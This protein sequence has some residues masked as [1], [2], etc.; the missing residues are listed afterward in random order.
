[1]QAYPS[2]EQT[3]P[4]RQLLL[5]EDNPLFAEQI[6][7]AMRGLPERWN[8]LEFSEGLQAKAFVKVALKPFDLVLVDLGLPDVS[9]IEVIRA[10]RER[11]VDM[12]IV[13]ISV[14]ASESAVLTAIEAG[15]NGYILKDESIE[16]ITKGIEQV[17]KGV[18]PLSP[19]LARYLFK[20]LSVSSEK[21]EERLPVKLSPREHET[22][23]GLAQGLSYELVAESMGVTLSTVQSNVRSLYRK[24]NVKSQSQ[25]V[26]MARS[27]QLL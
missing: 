7:D 10:C 16:E 20:H 11:F 13:V 17:L 18:Y 2:N 1:M 21:P 15:A 27:Y 5:V 12:P 19:R 3:P 14:V 6:T 22:L 25:A 26:S 9:G 24:L 4:L 23:Q 8:V